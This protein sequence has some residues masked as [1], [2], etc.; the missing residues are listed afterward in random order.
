[1]VALKS[2]SSDSGLTIEGFIGEPQLWQNAF[3]S[4]TDALHLGQLTIDFRFRGCNIKTHSISI[5][6]TV[7][8]YCCAL[9]KKQG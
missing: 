3:S 7:E 1:M 8:T 4:S 2:G 6:D 9:F 5:C